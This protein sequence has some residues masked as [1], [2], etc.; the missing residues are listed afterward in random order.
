MEKGVKLKESME[1]HNNKRRG[2]IVHELLEVL[3]NPRSIVTTIV[4]TLKATIAIKFYSHCN[5]IL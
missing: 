3:H 1:S 4:N 2:D 5:P